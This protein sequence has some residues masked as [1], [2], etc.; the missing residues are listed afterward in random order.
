MKILA[1]RK[2]IA[3]ERQLKFEKHISKQGLSQWISKTSN[4][5]H[6]SQN[7][8]QTPLHPSHP[9][10]KLGGAYGHISLLF[11]RYFWS[12]SATFDPCPFYDNTATRKGIKSSVNSNGGAYLQQVKLV[13]FTSQECV[14]RSL[15]LVGKI[16]EQAVMLHD[17][18]RQF[19]E[20]LAGGRQVFSGQGIFHI[21][22]WSML[23]AAAR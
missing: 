4:P 9:S 11:S 23:E 7:L 6:P 19:V 20:A 21:W 5:S 1:I 16:G 10:K 12:Q 18:R 22:F 2:F 15:C 8:F 3:V 17:M 14:E 13:I